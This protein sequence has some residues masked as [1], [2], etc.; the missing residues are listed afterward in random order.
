MKKYMLFLLLLFLAVNLFALTPKEILDRVDK[1]MVYRTIKYVGI[2]TI[3]KGR[4]KP[5][6][7]KFKAVAK[8]RDKAFI[9]FINPGDRGTKYLKLGDELWVKGAYAERADKISGHMLRESMMGSDFSYEDTM[10]NEKLIDKYN[11]KLIGIEKINGKECYKLELVSK[12]K[13]I[14]YPK[15]IV[16]VDRNNFVPLKEQ[17]FALS[18][19]LLKEMNI[20]EIKK[21]GGRFVPVKIKMEN[22]QRKN[23]YTILEMKKVVIDAP[24]SNSVFS[25]RNLER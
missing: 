13:K 22:K 1:N 17:F 15:R 2:M 20:L 9:E 14:S 16:W 19:M 4:R 8:G 25:K 7:K 23:S 11:V 6:V 5:R 12:V 21:I 18:G 3:K 24:L 10:E